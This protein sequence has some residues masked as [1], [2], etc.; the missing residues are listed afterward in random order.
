VKV[1][2]GQLCQ[3]LSE[4]NVQLALFVI[5]HILIFTIL[6]RI[7]WVYGKLIQDDFGLDYFYSTKM[8]L[9]QV[10]Y[11]DFLV[12]YPPVSL[13][14]MLLPRLFTSHAV[15]YSQLY[16]I[17][18]LVFDV[19]G[20][21][22]I[23]SIAELLGKSSWKTLVIYTLA[24]LAIGPIIIVRFDIIPAITLLGTLYAF[25]RGKFTISWVLLAIGVF[26]KLYSA[27]VIPILL[28]YHFKHHQ[29][30]EMA[31]AASAFILACL[32]ITVPFILLSPSGFL[33]SFSYQM[34]RNLQVETTYASVLLLANFFGITSLQIDHSSGSMNV[35]SPLANTFA[36]LSM[37]ITIVILLVIFLLY[38]RNKAKLDLEKNETRGLNKV[39]SPQYLIWLLPLV[40][41]TTNEKGNLTW[42]IFIMAGLMTYFVYPKDYGGLEY[43]EFLAIGMLVLRNATLII[44]A[45]LIARDRHLFSAKSDIT[46]RMKSH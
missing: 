24:L 4:R 37:P 14:F 43:G 41:I 44:F 38:F 42:L 11:R 25:L 7:G 46:L 26:T 21:F 27:V 22:L 31:R 18:M 28:I 8:M 12:E 1:R 17:E 32:I 2:I 29:Y 5:I 39:L 16:A 20:I 10:P 15:L 9:G 34:G 36:N 6:F 35:V 19:I 33:T 13:L 45:Y 3:R 23:A 30:R 40:P